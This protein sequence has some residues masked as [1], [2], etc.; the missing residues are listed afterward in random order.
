MSK[1][2]TDSEFVVIHIAMG[3]LRAEVIKSKLEAASIPVLL[4]YESAGPVLGLTMDGI[5]EVKVQVP[6]ELAEEARALTEP[7]DAASEEWEEEWGKDT[8]S[9]PYLCALRGDILS[10]GR[11]PPWVVGDRE[12]SRP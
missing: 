4:T 11:R 3:F 7:V 5:G 10:C 9:P 2:S 1:T 6:Q 8:P 12:E